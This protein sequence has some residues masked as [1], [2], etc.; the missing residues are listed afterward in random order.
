[1]KPSR[2]NGQRFSLTFTRQPRHLLSSQHWHAYFDQEEPNYGCKRCL[3]KL[4]KLVMGCLNAMLK[5]VEL[6]SFN[7]AQKRGHSCYMRIP[8]PNNNLQFLTARTFQQ[9]FFKP[10]VTQSSHQGFGPIKLVVKFMLPR[11]ALS[12]QLH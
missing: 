9:P 12:Y 6:L 4:K 11:R 1:M 8:L 2:T 5:F 10:S 7:L 3:I